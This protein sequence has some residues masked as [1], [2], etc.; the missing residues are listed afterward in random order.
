MLVEDEFDHA[1][2]FGDG[3]VGQNLACVTRLWAG[4]DQRPETLDGMLDHSEHGSVRFFCQGV[5][6]PGASEYQIFITPSFLWFW[7]AYQV[8]EEWRFLTPWG[9][10]RQLLRMRTS[11][12]GWSVEVRAEELGTY[13]YAFNKRLLIQFEL[14]QMTGE[15]LERTVHEEFTDDCGSFS[16]REYSLAASSES[17]SCVSLG[18]RFTY[19][20]RLG[21]TKPLLLEGEGEA[22]EYGSFIVG[23]SPDG[24]P[25]EFTSEPSQLGN[26]FGA[27]P[28]APHYLTPVY[29]R[30][31]VLSKY[32]STPS[33]F[34]ISATR[35]ECLNLWGIDISLNDQ[36]MVVVYLGDI[37]AHIPREEHNH[38]RIYNDLPEGGID[39]GRFRRDFLGQWVGSPDPIGELKTKVGDINSHCERKFG[40][41]IWKNLNPVWNGRWKY[42]FIPLRQ[43]RFRYRG[44]F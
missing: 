13:L 24:E 1:F 39:D 18:G 33:R 30:R 43:T 12:D 4:Q 32:I 38:W 44:Q 28:T 2:P 22:P 20:G 7:D 10:E 17:N 5:F 15:I 6:P 25:V 34:S 42:W 29:F 35:L 14:F 41:P 11:E 3:W 31:D 9:E 36:N 23:V 26:Y 37:G 16:Y 40:F 27:N 21:R 8:G 19:R